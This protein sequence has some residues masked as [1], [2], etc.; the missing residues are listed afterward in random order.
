[1]MVKPKKIFGLEKSRMHGHV[2][3]DSW[4]TPDGCTWSGERL[5]RKQSTSRPANDLFFVDP[6]DEAF[7]AS[8]ITSSD[9]QMFWDQFDEYDPQE[10]RCDKQSSEKAKVHR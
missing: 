2:S 6:V 8:T 9:A 3:Q 10:L 1:M 4:L 7:C 5:T